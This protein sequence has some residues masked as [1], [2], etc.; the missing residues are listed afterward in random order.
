MFMNNWLYLFLG[1]YLYSFVAFVCACK[2]FHR[3]PPSF[4]R[5]KRECVYQCL[6]GQTR[7]W[8]A[9]FSWWLDWLLFARCPTPSMKRIEENGPSTGHL[10]IGPIEV[11]FNNVFKE[12]STHSIEST[13]DSSVFSE[14]FSSLDHCLAHE[15]YVKVCGGILGRVNSKVRDLE[16]GLCSKNVQET[17]GRPTYWER[18]AQPRLK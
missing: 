9:G 13:P 18:C 10:L 4:C 8:Q 5:C 7:Y 17:P 6:L 15:P 11:L 1:N 3:E 14:P 2:V 12:G 16:A